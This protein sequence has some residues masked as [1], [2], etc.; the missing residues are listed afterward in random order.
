MASQG[1]TY[2][3]F[4]DPWGLLVRMLRSGSPAA[5]AALFRAGVEIPLRP[6]DYLLAGR[7]RRLIDEAP[8]GR[9]P[10]LLIVGAPRSGTTMAYQLIAGLLPV[11]YFS[12]FSSLFPR[13]PLAASKMVRRWIRRPTDVHSYYG[14]TAGW[15]APNDG[16]HIW[17][18][19]LGEDRYHA[20]NSL[21]LE[22]KQGMRKFLDAWEMVFGQPLVNKNNRNTDA[23]VLLAETLPRAHFLVIERDPVYVA[24][25]LVIARQQVQ[26]SKRHA[27]GLDSRDVAASDD[28]LGYVDEVCRQVFRID[29]NLKAQLTALPRERFTCLKYE[30]LCERPEESLQ[31]VGEILGVCPQLERMQQLEPL[32]AAN[33]KR[34]D[35]AEFRRIE[36]QIEALFAQLHNLDV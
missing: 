11:T 30:Q 27:W 17:S 18:Q 26:G 12:N 5:R 21:T 34:L 36:S 35:D 23:L 7:E 10:Q 33:Q 1:N 9:L 28:P 20:P 31:Q 4:R 24:Q 16:F 32:A 15:M 3:N 14:Q 6:V 2:A 29:E 19:W 22:Q 13:A 25:S 8:L